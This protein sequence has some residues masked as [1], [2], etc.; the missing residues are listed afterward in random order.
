MSFLSQR[1]DLL[2]LLF[3]ASKQDDHKFLTDGEMVAEILFILLA[4][5]DTTSNTL[6]F[7]AYLLAIN[8]EIQEKLANMILEYF[9]DN[10]VSSVC[11]SICVT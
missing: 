6:A 3:E 7:T 8:T 10:P 11:L 1:K 9:D 4:G 2:Q 5:Y